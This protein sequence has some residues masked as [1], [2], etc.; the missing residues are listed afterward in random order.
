MKLQ[1]FFERTLIRP[2][3]RGI[4]AISAEDWRYQTPVM[5]R[6]GKRCECPSFMANSRLQ[7]VV[8]VRMPRRVACECLTQKPGY[9]VLIE[10]P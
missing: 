10:T 4:L 8:R 9:G 2:G 5:L 1:I 6:T 7:P 3:P